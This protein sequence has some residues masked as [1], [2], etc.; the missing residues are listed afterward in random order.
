MV[1]A[2][3]IEE[4]QTGCAKLFAR[5]ELPLH[6]AAPNQGSSVS[7]SPPLCRSVPPQSTGSW[8]TIWQREPRF[9]ANLTDK[10]SSVARLSSR[11]IA[12][13]LAERDGSGLH[14][15]AQGDEP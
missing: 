1:E 3:G 4:T 8:Q 9:V 6:P 5:R 15:A 2:A 10:R 7:P 13:S 11:F 14:S 12:L